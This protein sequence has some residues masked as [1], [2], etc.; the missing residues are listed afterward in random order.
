MGGPRFEMLARFGPYEGGWQDGE[1]HNPEGLACDSDGNIY[2]ADEM[3]HRVQK[4]DPDGRVLW[5]IGAIGADGR[6]RPG[7]AAG[8]F[9]MHRA[10][11]VDHE[12]NLYVGDSQNSRS[13]SST[14]PV[15]SSSCSGAREMASASSEE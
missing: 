8:Q 9:K 11:H 10:V 13:R 3:N 2:V 5:K 4:L 15:A 12:D 6:P 1:F 14:L 7:T